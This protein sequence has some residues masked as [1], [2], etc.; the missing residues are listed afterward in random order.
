MSVRRTAVAVAN[1]CSRNCAETNFEA[2]ARLVAKAVKQGVGLLC[3]PECFAFIGA[4]G[5]LETAEFAQPLSGEIVRRYQ[6]LAR[7]NRSD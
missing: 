7:D 3:L 2:C 6:Q 1:L 4:P 5:T